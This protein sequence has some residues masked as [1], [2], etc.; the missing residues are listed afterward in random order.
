MSDRE[1]ANQIEKGSRKYRERIHRESKYADSHKNLPYKFSKPAKNKPN[2]V[3]V[4]C[5]KCDRIIDVTEDTIV[6]IC[7]QCKSIIKIT[8]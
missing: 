4:E 5:K 6:V 7:S 8:K 2:N 3:H 1:S